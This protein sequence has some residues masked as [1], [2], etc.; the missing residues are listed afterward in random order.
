MSASPLCTRLGE[1]LGLGAWVTLLNTQLASD[2]ADPCLVQLE[3]RCWS[4]EAGLPPHGSRYL[5]P[6]TTALSTTGS[7]EPVFAY[8]YH[9]VSRV[10]NDSR[11]LE[12][13]NIC[14]YEKVKGKLAALSNVKAILSSVE[15]GH[16]GWEGVEPFHLL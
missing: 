4:G 11:R 9:C 1:L 7:G 13:I 5:W 15:D 2:L 12:A 3:T 8:S 10:P 16:R 14:R 6:I